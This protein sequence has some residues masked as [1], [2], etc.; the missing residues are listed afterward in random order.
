MAALKA[1]GQYQRTHTTECAACHKE[2]AYSA[3]VCPHCGLKRHL[4]ETE[5]TVK[6]IG[7]L[8]WI[9]LG[10]LALLAAWWVLNY[11]AKMTPR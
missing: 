9:G 6:F 3:P 2:V 8:I 4:T 7:S 5:S 11:L 10:F 1:F